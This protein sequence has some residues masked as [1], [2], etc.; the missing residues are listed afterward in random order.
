MAIRPFE[1]SN[2]DGNELML[3]ENVI[4]ELKASLECRQKELSEEIEVTRA[5]SKPV[6]LDQQAVGRVSRID[7][8]QQQQ[9]HLSA[10]NRRENQ[11]ALIRSALSRI[12]NKQYGECQICEEPIELKRLRARPE[13]PV[14]L[15]CAQ[16]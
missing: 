14:C 5:N 9:M 2:N 11:L 10:L 1:T 12:Q 8:I 13:T 15:S 4:Q 7:A 3:S 16:K 6:A